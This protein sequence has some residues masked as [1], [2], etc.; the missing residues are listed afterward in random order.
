MRVKEATMR[1]PETSGVKFIGVDSNPDDDAKT[2][3]A[4]MADLKAPYYMVLDPK[5]EVAE[6]VGA[7][8]ATTFVVLDAD[9]RLRYR[10]A[11]DDSLDKP[12]KPYL[13]PAIAAVLAG[14]S[15]AVAESKPYGCPFPGYAGE[16]PLQ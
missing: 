6:L 16:C 10:G 3:F 1:F 15:P 11:L 13:V 5:Q 9:R 12:T 8:Q 7:D 2:A 4:K 14:K